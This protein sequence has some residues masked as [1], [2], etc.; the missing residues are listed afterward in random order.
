MHVCDL[1][2]DTFLAEDA[3]PEGTKEESETAGEEQQP[4]VPP[5]QEEE[6]TPS[7]E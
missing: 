3:A 6:P 4:V 1:G 5:T 7:Q 2:I